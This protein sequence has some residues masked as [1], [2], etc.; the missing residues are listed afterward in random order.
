MGGHAVYVA[1]STLCFAKLSLDDALHTIRE[2]RFAKADLSVHDGGPH[3]TPAEIVADVGKV[4]QRLKAANLP[5]AALHLNLTADARE[6]FRA[7]CRF[8]RLMTVPVLTVHGPTM[9]K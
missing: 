2:M 8:A 4:V 6:P 7:L 9:K 1:C 5:L 3:L